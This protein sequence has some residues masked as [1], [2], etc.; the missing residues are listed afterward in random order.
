MCC[1]HFCFKSSQHKLTRFNV[2][3]YPPFLQCL[4]NHSVLSIQPMRDCFSDWKITCI[5]K[6]ESACT[7]LDR[8]CVR[9]PVLQSLH[10]TWRIV[11]RGLMLSSAATAAAFW[12]KAV[13][14]QLLVVSCSPGSFQCPCLLQFIYIGGWCVSLESLLLFSFFRALFPL[15]FLACS[16]FFLSCFCLPLLTLL[17]RQSSHFPLCCRCVVWG[18]R[19]A[20]EEEN[21]QEVAL[22]VTWLL[23][24]W[25]QYVLPPRHAVSAA[26]AACSV[27]GEG[28][29]LLT[30]LYSCPLS[31]KRN[32]A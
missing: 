9:A 6:C 15:L 19:A 27:V 28:V 25:S 26:V 11:P 29:G 20:G 21:E 14:S 17:I 13:E 32:K 31:R 10:L 30:Y 7:C 22:W 18:L 1:V 16:F 8:T 2:G 12:S 23:R 24:A 3:I 4:I 5:H